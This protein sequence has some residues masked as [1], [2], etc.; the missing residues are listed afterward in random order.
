MRQLD[1]HLPVLHLRIGEHLIER[2]DRPTGHVRVRQRR[3]PR[4]ARLRREARR[5][6]GHQFGAV[7]DA[8]AVAGEAFVCGEFRQPSTAQQRANC[9]SLPTARIR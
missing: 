5:E 1:A 4:I 2:V 3:Q 9:A 6:Q 8:G 7:C